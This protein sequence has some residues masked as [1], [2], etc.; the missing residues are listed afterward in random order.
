MKCFKEKL[1]CPGHKINIRLK[2]EKTSEEQE[3]YVKENVDTPNE[4]TDMFDPDHNEVP[5]I[6]N[7]KNHTGSNNTV[8]ET[9]FLLKNDINSVL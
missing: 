6:V 3:I 9:D 2:K 8:S 1:D 5:S 7:K 4:L